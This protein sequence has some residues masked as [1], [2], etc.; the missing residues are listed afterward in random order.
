[1][2]VHDRPAREVLRLPAQADGPIS[3]PWAEFDPEWY[4]KRYSDAPA[5][6]DEELLEWH[7]TQGQRLGHSPNRYFDEEWQR[8][9][10]PGIAALIEA[11]SIASA[12]DAWCR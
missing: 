6:P 1:M 8:R 5:V 9:A 11:G 3:P 7:F 4:R 12:F 2:P 10:W